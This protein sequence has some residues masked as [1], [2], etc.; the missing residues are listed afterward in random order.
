LFQIQNGYKKADFDADFEFVENMANVFEISIKFYIFIPKL[1][2]LQ[3]LKA[4][5]DK[6]IEKTGKLF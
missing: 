3:T 6:M 2:F 4:N 5:A 1:D